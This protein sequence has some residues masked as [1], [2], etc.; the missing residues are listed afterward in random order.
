[1]SVPCRPLGTGPLL[2]PLPLVPCIRDPCLRIVLPL[3]DRRQGASTTHGL[4]PILVLVPPAAPCFR[5]LRPIFPPPPTALIL[6]RVFLDLPSAPL[7]L[8]RAWALP[9]LDP[10][11]IVPTVRAPLVALPSMPCRCAVP[12]TTTATAAACRLL[13]D[14]GHWL[15]GAPPH[16]C[17]PLAVSALQGRVAPLLPGRL[18]GHGRQAPRLFCSIHSTGAGTPLGCS[19]GLDMGGV[20]LCQGL[21]GVL[22]IA[23]G[24]LQGGLCRVVGA[25]AAPCRDGITRA[26]RGCRSLL[27]CSGCED[28][29]LSLGLGARVAAIRRALSIP[30]T[31]AG[32]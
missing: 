4:G 20:A 32:Q 9:F 13:A 10:F 25:A 31:A 7:A 18:T 22:W 15:P 23:V 28:R 26:F 17:A 24:L 5:L 14:C 27:A 11:L 1:M 16:P 19:T 12:S 6:V 21:L 3:P 30:T 8:L 29:G 2:R